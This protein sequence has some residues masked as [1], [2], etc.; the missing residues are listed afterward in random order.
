MALQTYVTH[1][2][3][4]AIALANLDAATARRLCEAG[5]DVKRSW[6]GNHGRIATT[7]AGPDGVPSPD[8]E[9]KLMALARL[10]VA[11]AC[12][13]KQGMDP[14]G[15]MLDLCKRGRYT[16]SFK[17]MTFGERGTR[18]VKMPDTDMR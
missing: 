7:P 15:V 6:F 4:N 17:Q 18:I 13:Y 9:E 10:D 5:L 8:E 3:A 16:G 12:D 14:A 2:E 1:L 11:F